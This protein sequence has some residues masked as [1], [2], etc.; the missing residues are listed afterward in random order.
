M[1]GRITS[2]STISCMPT[3]ISTI[4][5]GTADFNRLSTPELVEE[6]VRLRDRFAYETHVEVDA[7]NIAA[8]FYLDRARRELT[9]AGLDPSSFLGLIPETFDG[10]S[11]E[12]LGDMAAA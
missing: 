10:V 5:S 12:G 8:N 4:R 11:F 9:A 7:I 3:T 2:P 1:T 6:I